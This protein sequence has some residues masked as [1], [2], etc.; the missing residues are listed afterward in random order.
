MIT[1]NKTKIKYFQEI[2]PSPIRLTNSSKGHKPLKIRRQWLL[3][4]LQV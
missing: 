2:Y 4:L 3:T 1:E